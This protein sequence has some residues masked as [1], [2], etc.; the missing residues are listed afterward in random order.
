[1]NPIDRWLPRIVLAAC[2]VLPCLECTAKAETGSVDAAQ[3]C[4]V[5]KALRHGPAWSPKMCATVAEALNETGNPEL[6]RAV[7]TNESDLDERA[8]RVTFLPDGR[9]AHDLGLCG[10]R[11]IVD[12]D[13]KPSDRDRCQNGEVKGMRA[14]QLKDPVRNISAAWAIMATKKRH[15]NYNAGTASK[16][17]SYEARVFVIAA[18]WAGELRIPKR[19]TGPKWERI[20]TMARRIVEALGKERRS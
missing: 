12:P 7:C 1:M 11:C 14:H 8:H 9:I 6:M 10:V 3:L 18:A 2:L 20:K 15:G 5:K 13:A 19:A 16:A 4:A 17:R